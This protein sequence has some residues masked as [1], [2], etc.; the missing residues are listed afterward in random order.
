MVNTLSFMTTMTKKVCSS[1]VTV[2]LLS[3]RL[4]IFVFQI[5]FI[6]FVCVYLF[7]YLPLLFFCS[8]H[9][10]NLNIS[11][12]SLSILIAFLLKLKYYVDHPIELRRVAHNGFLHALKY[13]RAISRVDWI[14]RSALEIQAK[15]GNYKG[16]GSNKMDKFSFT[17]EKI[18]DNKGT[19]GSL[20]IKH[21]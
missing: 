7:S 10:F 21:L 18:K 17:G 20:Q 9:F 12:C 6:S 13:H 16:G 11:I 14:L 2:F 4:T 8:N 5:S 15:E 3:L 1:F 19:D